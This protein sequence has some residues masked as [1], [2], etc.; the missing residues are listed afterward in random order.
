MQCSCVLGIPD[1]VDFKGEVTIIADGNQFFQC[2]YGILELQKVS[3]G[4]NKYMIFKTRITP[5][6]FYI[7]IKYSNLI[8]RL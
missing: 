7:Y 8:K 1:N 5:C 2:S 3:I 6:F 4:G